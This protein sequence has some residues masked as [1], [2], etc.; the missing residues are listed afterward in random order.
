MRCLVT[1]ISIHL[2][3]IGV[4]ATGRKSLNSSDQGFFRSGLIIDNFD[5]SGTVQVLGEINE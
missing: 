4:M 1:T 3:E 5:I 2:A